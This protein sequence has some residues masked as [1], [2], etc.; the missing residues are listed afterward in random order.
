[1]ILECLYLKDGVDPEYASRVLRQKVVEARNL[2]S[3]VPGTNISAGLRLRD[4][5]IDWVEST[6]Q[7]LSS[8][9]LDTEA[10]SMV[11]SARYWRIRDMDE[12]TAR[13]WSLIES[14]I[15]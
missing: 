15:K 7:L 13:P 5:Y 4:L 11:N 1:M 6:E 3:G 14:E 9:A 8:F 10:P 12:R 2:K